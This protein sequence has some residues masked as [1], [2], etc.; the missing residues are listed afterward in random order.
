MYGL[1]CPICSGTRWRVV[2]VRRRPGR[3][4]RRREC[5]KCGKR[6]NTEER[7]GAQAGGVTTTDTPSSEKGTSWFRLASRRS[8]AR[9]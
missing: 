8:V 9:S 6:I 4:F 2:D 7:V 1:V 5:L 3:I